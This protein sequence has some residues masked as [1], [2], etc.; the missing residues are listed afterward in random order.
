MKSR[1]YIGLILFLAGLTL[2]VYS[3]TKSTIV[4][5]KESKVRAKKPGFLPRT[6]DYTMAEPYS[7]MFNFVEQYEFTKYYNMT[8]EDIQNLLTVSSGSSIAIYNGLLTPGDY[9]PANRVFIIVPV[10]GNYKT[11]TTH[12]L[13][14]L[15]G[16]YISFAAAKQYTDNYKAYPLKDQ[17][18]GVLIKTETLQEILNCSDGVRVWHAVLNG[19]R[20]IVTSEV[21]SIWVGRSLS[22]PAQ[23]YYVPSEGTVSLDDRRICPNNCDVF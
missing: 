17:V 4:V 1:I 10:D 19:N 14:G 21:T 6:L 22:T 20:T 2:C 3:C 23:D 13:N 16:S 12:I 7:L 5:D 15:T 8:K 18:R 11:I 9:T